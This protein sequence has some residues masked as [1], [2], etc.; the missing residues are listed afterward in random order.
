MNEVRQY[1]PENWKPLERW[2]PASLCRARFDWMWQEGSFE[3]YRCRDSGELLYL[4]P[5]G[6]CFAMTEVG[7]MLVDFSQHFE[8]CTGSPYPSGFA[9]DPL[10]FENEGED[11][12]PAPDS[13]VVAPP[14]GVSLSCLIREWAEEQQIDRAKRD[15]LLSKLKVFKILLLAELE[16]QCKRC[17][18]TTLCWLA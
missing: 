10:S 18:N 14:N 17:W 1:H 13:A 5:I 3:C 11:A 7:P 15:V 9:A 8:R 2:L 12:D 16:D 6:Q 4:D